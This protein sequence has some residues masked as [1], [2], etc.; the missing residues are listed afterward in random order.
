MINLVRVEETTLQSVPPV[1]IN[2]LLKSASND[3]DAGNAEIRF[4]FS[5]PMLDGCWSRNPFGDKSYPRR[6]TSRLSTGR[7]VLAGLQDENL[8]QHNRLTLAAVMHD[9]DIFITS[10]CAKDVEQLE[11]R[12]VPDEGNDINA[13]FR[14]QVVHRLR[15]VSRHSVSDLLIRD[16]Y[17]AETAWSAAACG[18]RGELVTV[19]AANLLS[20][21]GEIN[22]RH[23]LKCVCRGQDAYFSSV[24]V[25]L[26]PAIRRKVVAELDAILASTD[27]RPAM[28]QG[29]RD[30]L[31]LSAVTP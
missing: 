25:P 16:L 4:T 18:V 14:S 10:Y 29:V 7:P 19:L 20:R 28:W 31:A 2:S 12:R 13:L 15:K 26:D 6:T 8:N 9:L 21:G 24:F 5:K 22:L 27:S 30:Q 1:V 3:V 23:F 17:D 11:F